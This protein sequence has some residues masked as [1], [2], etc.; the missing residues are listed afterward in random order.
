MW[1]SS[2]DA[3]WSQRWNVGYHTAELLFFLIAGLFVGINGLALALARDGSWFAPHHWAILA[4]G[5]IMGVMLLLFRRYRRRHDPLILPLIGFLMGWG[6][7]LMARLAPVFLWRHF[8]WM[9]LGALALTSI[10]L[11]P[12]NLDFLRRYR[13][14]WLFAGLL[15]LT[16]TL[17]FG[18]NPS[19]FGA[20]LWLRFPLLPNVYFQPS[21]L[22]KLL[23]LIFLASY[24]DGR[25]QLLQVG[26]MRVGLLSAFPFLAPLLLMW[27]FCMILLVLQ[28]DLGAATLFFLLFLTLLYVA[29]G[30]RLYWMAGL[31]LL[32][33]AGIFAYTQF[34]LVQLR[35]DAWWNPWPEATDRAYQIVQSL[36]ALSA[37]GVLGQ[38]IYQGFPEYIPVVHSDFVFAAIGEEW[39]LIGSLGILLCFLLLTYR[40]M[41]IALLVR[42]PFLSYLSAGIATMFTAQTLL[43]MG[44]VTKALPLTGV[45]LPFVSYGGSSMLVSCIMAGLLLR[46]SGEVER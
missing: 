7:I 39:G 21:E 46:I 29:T 37:G 19:G 35:I 38:G 20:A 18:V 23:L 4:W 43:I 27:G 1:Q 6:I 26:Q 31:G 41:R 9:S 2:R 34:A 14:T 32:L 11:L 40:G 45:T 22:L 42:R 44:G 12:A 36:Y 30:E 5:G 25:E 13:Y 10:A 3:I 15:L 28:Q 33:L 8:L 24:F 17:I 16:A